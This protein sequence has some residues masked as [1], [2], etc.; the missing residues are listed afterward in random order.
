MFDSVNHPDIYEYIDLN[1][2]YYGTKRGTRYHASEEA[3]LKALNNLRIA[4]TDPVYMAQYEAERKAQREEFEREEHQ[5][6]RE[7]QE[8]KAREALEL[9]ESQENEKWLMWE[10]QESNLMNLRIR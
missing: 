10:D 2:E 4:T 9:A 6:R 5:E 8:R 1:R 3:F 7:S